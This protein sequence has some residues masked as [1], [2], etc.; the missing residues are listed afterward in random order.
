MLA[1]ISWWTNTWVTAPL[2]NIVAYYKCSMQVWKWGN[3]E[4]G[5]FRHTRLWDTYLSNPLWNVY[6]LQQWFMG[7]WHSLLLCYCPWVRLGFSWRNTTYIET[8]SILTLHLS[9]VIIFIRFGIS[10]WSDGNLWLTQRGL[11]SGRLICWR[12]DLETH[13]VEIKL[14][15]DQI[16]L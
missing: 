4:R 7:S 1:S 8:C 2:E 11:K 14:F 5:C 15:A 3:F 13:L 16:S 12:Q 10:V 6:H 9:V